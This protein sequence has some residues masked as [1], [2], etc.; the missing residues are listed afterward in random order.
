[1]KN[2]LKICFL[3]ILEM[4]TGSSQSLF[5][6]ETYYM[7]IL[8]QSLRQVCLIPSKGKILKYGTKIWH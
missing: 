6:L 1:M 5:L 3:N 7:T 4:K 8:H 2:F